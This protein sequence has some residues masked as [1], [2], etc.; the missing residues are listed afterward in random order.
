[1]F[2]VRNKKNDLDNDKKYNGFVKRI[3]SRVQ[4]P[5]RPKVIELLHS[6][7][8]RE[9]YHIL[10]DNHLPGPVIEK[11]MLL[12]IEDYERGKHLSLDKYASFVA[13]ELQI[14]GH[15]DRTIYDM[16]REGLLGDRDYQRIMRGVVERMK[17]STRRM[18]GG[19]EQLVKKV[20][21]YVL[22]IIGTALIFGSDATITGA[23]IGSSLS[24]SINIYFGFLILVLAM[25][26]MRRE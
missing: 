16:H 10:H 7:Q 18:S 22:F 3:S 15:Y 19:L 17:E 6:S 24:S 1:M 5:Y 14:L 11:A 4:E 13:Q 2:I 9:T 8:A 25:V 21:I 12:G 20:A 26:L 23:V